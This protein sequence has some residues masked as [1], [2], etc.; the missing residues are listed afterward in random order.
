MAQGVALAMSAVV[1]LLLFAILPAGMR[2]D[3][4]GKLW[5]LLLTA[6]ALIS[7]HHSLSVAVIAVGA[8]PAVES[9]QLLSHL[10]GI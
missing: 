4:G 10:L 2:E 9:Q 6:E 1:I 8:C 7:G 3:H 5:F